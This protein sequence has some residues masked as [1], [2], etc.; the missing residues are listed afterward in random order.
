MKHIFRLF[1]LSTFLVALAANAWAWPSVYPTGTT[2]YDPESS[3][4]GYTLFSPM[5]GARG[6][7]D[8]YSKP[9]QAYLI[10]MNGNVVHEWKLP[11][12]AGLHVELLPNG[13][14]LATGRTD[15]MEPKDRL[16]VKLDLDGIAGW[17][18]ELDWDGNI[19]FKY[20]D[21]GMHHDFEKLANG[22]YLFVSFE[23]LPNEISEKVRGGIYGTEF[24]GGLM[25]S[26]KLVEVNRKGKVVW[27]WHAYEHL[28][29]D[30]DIIG[31][32]HPRVEWQHINDIDEAANGDLVFS[33]RHVDCVYVLDKKT[34]NIKSRFGNTAYLDD[35]TGTLRVRDF[36]SMVVG[37][38]NT[39]LGGPHDAHEIEPG[40]PGAGNIMVYDNGM[41]TNT[42]RALEFNAKTGEVV[43][44]STDTSIGRRHFSSFISGAER[45][46]NG[47]TLIC[48][49]ANGRFFE[50]TPENKIVW[51]YIN[52]YLT[53]SMFNYTVF[54]AHRYAPDY[55]KNFKNLSPAKGEAIVPPAN[56]EFKVTGIV[57]V[58]KSAEEASEDGPT[59]HT[60]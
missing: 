8:F 27:E 56:A 6:A 11:F 15:R 58:D 54:R 21:Q 59:M 57:A 25:F 24:P 13:H 55:C 30:I 46:P 41:Y 60:Y 50:T 22:N 5:N 19:V 42:S 40:L 32:I 35:E 28:D 14:L 37:R 17:I 47:N 51:E 49:G 4:N 43:W 16:S 52:P 1:T 48:S 53:N 34:G 39:T 45:L 31:P 7:T 38:K 26:D 3:F 10:D 18:Y 2:L 36:G 33:A 29:V 9:G 12:P 20:Y 44:E 23:P